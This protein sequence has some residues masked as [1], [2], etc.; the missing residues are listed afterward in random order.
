M[1]PTTFSPFHD[2]NFR[3]HWF[4]RGYEEQME[5]NFIVHRDS[6]ISQLKKKIG[7]LSDYELLG[8]QSGAAL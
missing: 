4:A 2:R 6:I 5:E 3:R 8:C 1:F 7:N